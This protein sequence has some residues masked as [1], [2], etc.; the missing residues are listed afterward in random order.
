[1][2]FSAESGLVACCDCSSI[3]PPP[4]PPP[5][6][7]ST[8]YL[9]TISTTSGSGIPYTYTDCDGVESG[10]S[11]GGASGTDQD[12]FCAL[13]GTVNANGMS[14]FQGGECPF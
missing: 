13:E 6:P 3:P 7:G 1:L 4:P 5:P 2:C 14:L 8:C 9:Y 10:G 12:S 11:L